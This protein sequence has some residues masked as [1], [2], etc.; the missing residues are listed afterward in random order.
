MFSSSPSRRSSSYGVIVDVGSGSVGIG[1][2]HSEKG[3]NIPH[4]IYAHREHIRIGETPTP[5]ERI[6]AMRQAL[7]AATLQ[8][9]EDG[10]KQLREYDRHANID[11]IQVVCAAPWSETV[12][13]IIHLEKDKPFTITK[14]WVEDLIEKAQ[15]QNPVSKE[16][17]DILKNLGMEV[18]EESIVDIK[19]NGYN[20]LTPYGNEAKEI[21]VAHTSGL[22]PS[23]VLAA[24]GEIEKNVISGV[25]TNAHTYALTLYCVLRDLYPH[26]AN[27]LLV[28]VTGEAT[29]VGVIQDGVLLETATA[30]Y[31]A[32]TL[33][34][35]IASAL[36]TIPEEARA[37]IASFEHINK[38]DAVYTKVIE[39]QASFRAEI[40][41]V[42]KKVGAKY[43]LPRTVFLTID[44]EITKY[45]TTLFEPT[46]LQVSG[47]EKIK[48]ITVSDE[49]VKQLATTEKGIKNDVFLAVSAR[50]FHKLCACHEIEG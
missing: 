1:I 25:E 17:D 46:L 14:D 38:T 22:I 11:E 31:G 32:F 9:S 43:V 44:P 27:A 21:R 13:Q 28:D 39:A 45:F 34:R 33:T 42:L 50:F 37:Y 47:L 15:K 7:F 35:A 24:I 3:K 18:V 26:T 2:A 16:R 10:L 19:V 23:D 36:N 49:S 48:I 5:D 12:T 8:L 4:I 6:R 41:A 29:E 30:P 40:E 20:T